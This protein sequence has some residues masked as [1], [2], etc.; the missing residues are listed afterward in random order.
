MSQV[1]VQYTIK[2]SGEYPH[3]AW[4]DL[5]GDGVLH[6]C[7]IMRREQNGNILYFKT[8]DLDSIDKRRLVGILMDRNA[9]NF[10]LWDLMAQKTLGNG[11]NALT[12]FHQ[13]VKQLTPTGKTIDPRAGQVGTGTA[14][15]APAPI[16]PITQE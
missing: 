9:R 6:E 1:Q 11:V 14:R 16:A 8:N 13:L 7:A 10:P 2:A 3:V 4:I 15:L 5:S 12:Y